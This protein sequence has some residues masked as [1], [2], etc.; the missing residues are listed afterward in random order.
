[1]SW[2]Q[3]KDGQTPL[4]ERL[5]RLQKGLCWIC[6]KPMHIN[7]ASFD[8]IVPL[9]RGGTNNP[10]NKL[11]AHV[12]CNLKRGNPVPHAPLREV[13]DEALRRIRAQHQDETP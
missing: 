3:L 6:C 8:H 2:P 9:S 5:Y 13:V 1:M 7:D 4:R 11:L 12:G 10:K